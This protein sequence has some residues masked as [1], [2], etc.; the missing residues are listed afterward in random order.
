MARVRRALGPICLAWLVCQ[1]A[2]LT[3]VPAAVAF[4][5]GDAAPGCGCTDAMCPMHHGPVSGSQ[6]CA[7]GTTAGPA[8]LL[9]SLMAAVGLISSSAQ[10]IDVSPV[11][12]VARFT[13]TVITRQPVPPDPPPPRA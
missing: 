13:D 1:T 2:A 6:W 7:Q 4:E 11:A 9:S 3:V 8:A 12:S 5:F 10:A